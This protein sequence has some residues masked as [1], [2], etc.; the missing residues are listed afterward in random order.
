MHRCLPAFLLFAAVLAFAS[1]SSGD[2]PTPEYI[3]LCADIANYA[4]KASRAFNS[5]DEK[6][7]L[8]LFGKAEAAYAQ[9]VA[10]S[11]S[12]PY[13]FMNFGN[14]LSNANRFDESLKVLGAAMD[15]LHADSN[16]DPEAVEHVKDNLRRSMY[17]R[18]S[19][20]RD[21]AYQEGQGNI[22]EAR[23]FALQQLPLSPYPPR[24]LHDIATMELM[25]CDAAPHMCDSARNRLQQAQQSSVVQYM[26]LRAKNM[27]TE[28]Q[29][30][31]PASAAVLSGDDWLQ[32]PDVSSYD[33]SLPAGLVALR[34][35]PPL[36]LLGSQ[37]VLLFDDLNNEC[38]CKMLSPASDPLFDVFNNMASA[39]DPL[40]RLSAVGKPSYLPAVPL[41]SLVQFAAT[42]FYHW[43]C[44]VLPRLV[45]AQS[46]WGMPSSST[47]N[48]LVPNVLTAFMMQSLQ[49]LGV[50]SPI[51]YR[52][53][54]SIGKAPLLFVTWKTQS[55]DSSKM[56]G[57]SLAH[58]HALQMLRTR[59]LERLQ[60]Q[61]LQN[62]KPALNRPTIVVAS[63]GDS[64]G[65]RHFDENSLV[66]ALSLAMPGHD[67]VLSNGSQ[68]LF[69]NLALFAAASAVVGVHGGAL[70]NIV[71]C[72]ASIPL[73]EIG[74]A[75]EASWHYEH[76]ANALQLRYARVLADADPLH[77]SVGAATISVNISAVVLRLKQM[78]HATPNTETAEL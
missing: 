58:P 43:M 61:L 66:G 1:A 13:A 8:K 22:T 45:V 3:K 68:P 47:Y 30:S 36:L 28:A 19:M 59:L 17:G 78:I 25:L 51:N 71:V 64:T 67:V 69:D 33:Q 54:L 14:A 62:Q 73:V 29:E 39:E 37:G 16:A 53:R 77:R 44:E 23:E 50:T 32:C 11:P 57:F 46:V 15:I 7:A 52:L 27:R 70:A 41:L 24:I 9:A 2:H 20:R 12:L 42:S 38:A 74:F 72:S 34:A 75:S 65:M 18:A 31:C 6:K 63:R 10:M 60:P 55:L 40:E 76:V 49:A 4:Q 56:S 35:A 5:G 48:V 21:M 26:T